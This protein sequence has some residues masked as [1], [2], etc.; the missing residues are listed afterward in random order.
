M[1]LPYNVWTEEEIASRNTVP[2]GDYPFVI[3]DAK[4]TKTKGG[5]DKDGAPKPIRDMLEVQFEFHDINGTVRKCT[6]W[7]VFMEQMDWKL[8]HLARSINMLPHYE[9]KEL[10]AHHLP[11]KKGVFTLGIKTMKSND[12]IE[13]KVNFIKDYLEG[14]SVVNPANQVDE[15]FNDD[16]KF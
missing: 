16:I 12:G 14:V 1:V 11:R 9:A 6:D 7:I 4:L 10:D 8:R 15:N 3:L 2:E 13:K 5:F